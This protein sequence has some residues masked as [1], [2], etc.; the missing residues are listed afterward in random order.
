MAAAALWLVFSSSTA[1]LNVGAGVRVRGHAF[2][3][4]GSNK[5]G[6]NRSWG[7]LRPTEVKE[8][9]DLH[10]RVLPLLCEFSF[11]SDESSLFVCLRY[12]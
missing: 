4:P 9:V 11:F 1:V 12:E 10:D 8:S 7:K 3:H 5:S 6:C 2:L